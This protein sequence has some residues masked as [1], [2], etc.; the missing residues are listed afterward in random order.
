MATTSAGR[1]ARESIPSFFNR[2]GNTISLSHQI[3]L[4]LHRVSQSFEHVLHY[5]QQPDGTGLLC[6]MPAP[7]SDFSPVKKPHRSQHL[8]RELPDDFD[9]TQEGQKEENH[10]NHWDDHAEIASARAYTKS[11]CGKKWQLLEHDRIPPH[12]IQ[13][14]FDQH[15]AGSRNLAPRGSFKRRLQS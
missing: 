13:E 11:P 6:T 7:E 10:G 9:L 15:L 5:E 4:T 12:R 2:I 8:R 1:A 14:H 3:D